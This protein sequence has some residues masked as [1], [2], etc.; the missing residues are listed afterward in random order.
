MM[1]GASPLTPTLKKDCAVSFLGS[2]RDVILRRL[3]YDLSGV[4]PAPLF[5]S[6]LHKPLQERLV[7]S[8]YIYQR[9]VLGKQ[10]R[11]Y[12]KVV[13]LRTVRL[14]I[15]EELNADLVRV[16]LGWGLTIIYCLLF[17]TISADGVLVFAHGIEHSRRK[18][19]VILGKSGGGV[20]GPIL[21]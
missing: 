15:Q 5:P 17:A 3:I 1:R 11:A 16:T 21:P 8:D 12:A 14:D 20:A 9:Y 4:E 7:G 2:S 13:Q 10:L 6:P 18:L 19:R